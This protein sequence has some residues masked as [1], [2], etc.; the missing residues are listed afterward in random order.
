MQQLQEGGDLTIHIKN[1]IDLQEIPANTRQ[2]E[3]VGIR[4]HDS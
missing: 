3:T 2:L 4:I 1:G